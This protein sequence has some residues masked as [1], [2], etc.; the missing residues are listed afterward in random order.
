MIKLLKN[1]KRI[2]VKFFIFIRNIFIRIIA[3]YIFKNR[4]ITQVFEKIQDYEYVIIKYKAKK[5]SE[6]FPEHFY[7]F[8]D[9]DFL[10]KSNDID[11]IADD[12]FEAVL[13]IDL[14]KIAKVKKVKYNNSKGIEIHIMLLN[15]IV[16][17][18]HFQTFEHY[19]IAE[20]YIEYCFKNRVCENNLYINSKEYDF[21]I[22]LIECLTKPYK[23]WHYNFVI[24]NINLLDKDIIK[25]AVGDN[26]ELE[27]EIMY[28]FENINK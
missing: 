17:I 16:F 2:V 8:T 25:L 13:K 12:A 21:I 19:G 14:P 9:I 11:G 1:I 5:Q 26:K 3:K 24:S 23:K 27:K 20:H 6:K 18:I 28:F 10:V 4:D 7:S 15:A 22:R